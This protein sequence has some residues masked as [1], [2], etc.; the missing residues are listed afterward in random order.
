MIL[1]GGRVI[2]DLGRMTYEAAVVETYGKQVR[3]VKTGSYPTDRPDLGR[4]AVDPPFGF[5]VSIF[6]YPPVI[7]TMENR[8][9]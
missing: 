3:T 2:P 4:P 8:S 6:T 7:L 9:E 1:V 5:P